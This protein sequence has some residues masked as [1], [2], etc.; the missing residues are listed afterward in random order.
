MKQDT[1]FENNLIRIGQNASEN[2]D[3]I[4]DSDQQDIWFHLENLSSCHIVIKITEEYPITKQI[5]YYCASLC[6]ENTKYKNY[7]KVKVMY[8]EIKNVTR[9]KTKGMVNCKGKYNTVTI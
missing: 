1:I 2:D 6:K 8:T 4:D 7:K 3:L 5:I 9:T